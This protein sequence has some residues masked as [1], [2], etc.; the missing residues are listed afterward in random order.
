[1]AIL[2]GDGDHLGVLEQLLRADVVVPERRVGRDV[3]FKSVTK[4]Q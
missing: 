4:H 1:M 2:V 3:T